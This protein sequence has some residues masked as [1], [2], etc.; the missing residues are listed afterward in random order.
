MID[1]LD[2]IRNDIAT[3][4]ESGI[5]EVVNYGR[6]K[7]GLIPL[8]AGEGD[9][10]TP[11][12]ISAAAKKSLDEGETFYTYQRGIPELR[13]ALANY[14]QR[15]YGGERS[16]ENFYVTGSGMQAIMSAVQCVV[17]AGDEVLALTPA[18]PNIFGAVQVA[19]AKTIAVP[20]Q[21]GESGWGVD[22][23]A[24]FA[25][26]TTKTRALFINSPGNPTGV[27]LSREQLV[28]IRDFA[29]KHDLW[30]IADE[31]YGRFCFDGAAA[32]SFLEIMEPEEKLLVVNTFSKNWAM[33]GWRIGWIV[34]PQSLGGVMENLVQYNTS[35]VPV[36][37]QRAAV[38]ALEEGEDFLAMQVDQVRGVRDLVCNEMAT[39]SRVRSAPPQG[40][41]YLFFAVDGERDSR[42]LAL[43][44]IDEANVGL[45]P[46]GAFGPGGEGCLRLC[47]AGSPARFGQ[48]LE[49]LQPVL[50]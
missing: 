15:I 14:H 3:L 25:K 4:P 37:S 21:F 45:A 1:M 10:P 43:R 44:L 22:L 26:R 13:E 24:L 36:F 5:V 38:A 23:D 41:F 39:W 2:A 31:V 11:D 32:P 12:L 8:W 49:R 28:A 42:S 7:E 18:W 9:L 20:M 50:G 27:T 6:G 34:A 47:L 19:G 40:A 46:G 16:D 29:R 30:I 35:G 17:G 33:T 48:A